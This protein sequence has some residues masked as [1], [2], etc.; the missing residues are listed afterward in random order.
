M[1]IMLK[2][3]IDFRNAVFDQLISI[4]NKKKD[5]FIITADISAY[6]LEV[7]KKKFKRNFFNVGITEQ[8][9]IAITCGMAMSKKKK[10]LHS[11]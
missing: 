6:S 9:M 3:K 4:A 11:V 5:V 2:N 1:N 7:F 10:Y 8:S